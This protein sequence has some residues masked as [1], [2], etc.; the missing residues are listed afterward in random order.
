MGYMRL[1][2]TALITVFVIVALVVFVCR[3][4]PI[5]YAIR[6]LHHSPDYEANPTTA[7]VTQK[8]TLYTH[9]NSKHDKLIVVFMGGCGLFSRLKSIYGITNYLDEKLGGDGTGNYDVV[10]FCYPTRF[11]HTVLQSM[12][13][14]NESLQDFVGYS[15]IHAIG[16][17]F[18]A[19]LAGAFYQKEAQKHVSDSMQIPQIGMHFKSF[20]GLSG[21]YELNFNVRLVT[22]L[23]DYY[24]MRNVPAKRSY[25]CYNMKIPKMVVSCISDFLIAQTVKFCQ[26]EQASTQCK[27]YRTSN[28][29]HAFMQFLNI[30]ETIETLDE[31]ANFILK[32]DGITVP[33]PKPIV[34][35]LKTNKMQKFNDGDGKGGLGADKSTTP[36]PERGDQK[37][38]API[39]TSIEEIDGTANTTHIGGRNQM[40]WRNTGNFISD[41]DD[42]HIG[43]D[44]VTTTNPT[45]I[46]I[47]RNKRNIGRGHTES[48]SFLANTTSPIQ[49]RRDK[50]KSTILHTGDDD[51]TRNLQNRHNPPKNSATH[52]TPI[53]A[54]QNQDTLAAPHTGTVS[55]NK[56]DST[57]ELNVHFQRNRVVSHTGT[58]TNNRNGSS[59][60]LNSQFQKNSSVPHTGTGTHNK[61]D[62]SPKQNSQFQKN[63]AVPHTGTDSH[64]KDN[65]SPKLISQF[66]KNSSIPHTGTDDFHTNL[67]EPMLNRLNKHTD[68]H[69]LTGTGNQWQRGQAK[70]FKLKNTMHI[71]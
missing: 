34:G 10:T 24:I 53:Q 47:K 36:I 29:P 28:L 44:I 20:V 66:Q 8:Y 33:P 67:T 6:Q 45:A 22:A 56:N 43:N 16:V 39:H 70:P 35:I 57:L 2:L 26:T 13:S 3:P 59:P 15:S 1:F 7:Q 31:V 5:K 14:I 54:I 11:Q 46:Q 55:F 71:V 30:P 12:L 58:D 27:I 62:S 48:S 32:L 69:S 49:K 68:G 63:S 19:L 37:N 9:P 61:N 17:S 38:T 25:S 23:A 40:F 50:H 64:N 65:S 60:K 21:L 51:Y 52:S 4:T 41:R 18:G 42:D